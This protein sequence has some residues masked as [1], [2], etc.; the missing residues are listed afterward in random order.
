MISFVSLM[1]ATAIFFAFMGAL[2]GWN[3][4]LVGTAG[5][6]LGVFAI[7]QFD[8]ILRGTVF[9]LMS[10]DQIF[11]VQL[12]IFMSIVILAY[13]SQGVVDATG[14]R[15]RIQSGIL[16]AIVGFGNGYFVAGSIWYFL[17]INLYPF[18]QFVSAP[19]PGSVSFQAIETMP[20]VLLG[21][22]IA[23]NG[24]LLAVTV[25]VLLFI[26]MMVM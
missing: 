14:R 16:G 18:P 13:R 7:F 22:G 20:I 21:G 1:W 25:I 15:G 11:G 12:I 5:I 26:V 19:A 8:S 2:R 3:R 24:D 9:L 23:G 10:N 17:D 4:E 6:V